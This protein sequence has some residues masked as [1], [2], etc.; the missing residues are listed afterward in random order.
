MPKRV[1]LRAKS[2]WSA[3]I[4]MTPAKRLKVLLSFT[5]TRQSLL[6]PW[7]KPPWHIGKQAK[8]RKQTGCHASYANATRITPP[9][10]K[11]LNESRLLHRH[12]LPRVSIVSGQVTGDGP[13]SSDP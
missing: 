9:A 8:W 10:G 11:E 5:T 6:A 7:T 13:V 12:Q 4:A 1:C 2:S 3:E